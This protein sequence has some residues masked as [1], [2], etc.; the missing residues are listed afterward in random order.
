MQFSGTLKYCA[1][2]FWLFSTDRTPFRFI[3]IFWNWILQC[4]RFSYWRHMENAGVY[5]DWVN[6]MRRMKW[7]QEKRMS[8]SIT[9]Y[10]YHLAVYLIP[11]LPFIVVVTVLAKHIDAGSRMLLPVHIWY[12]FVCACP[13]T[14]T[15][16]T[17]H[18]FF[19]V[20]HPTI[21]RQFFGATQR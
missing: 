1:Y 6:S 16:S 18:S 15:R 20:F 5:I 21:E 13:F 19:F 4:D 7:M 10:Y 12:M 3:I 2:I 17:C 9:T 14:V 8:A 11:F